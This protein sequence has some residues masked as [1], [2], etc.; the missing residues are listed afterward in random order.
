MHRV[1]TWV[2]VTSASSGATLQGRL[3]QNSIISIL[4]ERSYCDHFSLSG[5]LGQVS[6][7][8]RE[9]LYHIRVATT[10][11]VTWALSA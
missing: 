4:G 3:E 9:G 2:P 6:P 1:E 5:F 7:A 11:D 10:Q 8:S